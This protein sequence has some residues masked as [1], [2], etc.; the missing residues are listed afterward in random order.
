MFRY[1]QF[2]SLLLAA[3]LAKAY[4]APDPD[5]RMSLKVR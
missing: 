4:S 2:A 3:V 1:V 5:L